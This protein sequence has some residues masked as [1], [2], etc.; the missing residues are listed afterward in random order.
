MRGKPG[1]TKASGVPGGLMADRAVF[2]GGTAASSRSP[3]I[4]S[5]RTLAGLRSLLANLLLARS[6]VVGF[7]RNL[8]HQL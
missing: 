5:A 2:V 4:L 7:C 1:E 3:S 8:L 6:A